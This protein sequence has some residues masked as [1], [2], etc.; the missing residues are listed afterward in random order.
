MAA[1]KELANLA[2]HDLGIYQATEG[3]HQDPR[4]AGELAGLAVDINE[5][6]HVDIGSTG[7][8]NPVAASLVKDVDRAARS[9]D[10]VR[11]VL[12]PLGHVRSDTYGGPKIERV[13]KGRLKD[14]HQSHFHISFYAK[15]ERL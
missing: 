1:L 12:G 11:T 13:F 15:E 9:M 7:R 2:G 3:L 4:H 10:A 5:I 8:M 14:E 6:D